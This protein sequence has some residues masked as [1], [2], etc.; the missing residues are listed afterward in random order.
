MND[1]PENMPQYTNDLKQL[2]DYFNEDIETL[3]IS[4]T[5]EHNALSD[6]KFNLELFKALKDKY[7]PKYI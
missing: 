3:N 7:S 2:L 5:S 4:N 1:L 6:A